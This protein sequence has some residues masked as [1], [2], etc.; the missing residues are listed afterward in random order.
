MITYRAVNS[1]FCY[2]ALS[3]VATLVSL[4]IFVLFVTDNGVYSA[5]VFLGRPLTSLRPRLTEE[6]VGVSLVPETCLPPPAAGAEDGLEPLSPFLAPPPSPACAETQAWGKGLG[7]PPAEDWPAP[8]APP[9]TSGSLTRPERH[10][11]PPPRPYRGLLS[12]E[13]LERSV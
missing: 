7:W 3:A 13:A 8:R 6:P 11:W 9:L 4:F 10:R 12:A 1:D 2:F 5:S